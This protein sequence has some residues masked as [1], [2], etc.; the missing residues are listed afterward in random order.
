MLGVSVNT[1]DNLV[2]SGRLPKPEKAGGTPQS[3]VLFR[4]ADV[5]EVTIY[6]RVA[7][8]PAQTRP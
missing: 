3:P 7:T 1:I 4:R 8:K 5:R 6:R 2:K